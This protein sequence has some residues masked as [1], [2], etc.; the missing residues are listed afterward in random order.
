MKRLHT[1][2]F[3]DLAWC[4]SWIRTAMTNVLVVFARKM[5]INAA[6][7]HLVTRI[8]A[9]HQLDRIV[10]LGS[11]GGGA[12]LDVLGRLRARPQTRDVRLIL[13]DQYPNLDAMAR[14][15]DRDDAA[16]IRYLATPVDATSLSSAPVGLRTMVNCFHHMRPEQARQILASAQCSGLPFLVFEAEDNEIPRIVWLLSFPIAL[17][18]VFCMA[19]YFTAFVRPLSWRQLIFTYVVPVVPLLFAWDGHNSVARIY[20]AGDLDELLSSLEP[21]TNYRWEKGA[22]KNERGRDKGLYLL[23]EPVRPAG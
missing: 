22:G 16:P 7:D 2:E 4:P 13:S 10:D 9:E 14:F 15:P 3:E 19:L 23:G 12:M 5:G 20:T 21:A 18:L 6:V 1:L 17:P 11:G 8:L